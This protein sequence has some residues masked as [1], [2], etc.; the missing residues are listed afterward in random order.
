[1]RFRV[2]RVAAVAA[3]ALTAVPAV[4]QQFSDS[5]EF[6]EAI[7]KS[8]G[9]KVNKFLLDRSLR[10]VNAKDRGTGEGALHIVARRSDV[11]YLR[12]LLQADDANPNLQDNR[13]NTPLIVAVEQN[14]G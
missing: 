5:Y 8:D 4:A 7:R 1:M 9:S 3:L 6:L 11:L 12:A 10:I 14:W 2:F 13:G